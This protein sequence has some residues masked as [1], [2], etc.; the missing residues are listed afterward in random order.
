MRALCPFPFV[1]SCGLI[2]LLCCS[3]FAAVELGQPVGEISVLDA[4]GKEL[5]V[6]R[7]SG[8]A[9]RRDLFLSRK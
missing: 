9:G 2:L 8:A 3:A 1:S 6:T 7:C 5:V 4:H